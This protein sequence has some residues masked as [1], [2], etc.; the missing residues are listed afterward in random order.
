M[1]GHKALSFFF[2]KTTLPSLERKKKKKFI[3][4][5]TKDSKMYLSIAS[6]SGLEVVQPQQSACPQFDGAVIRA[7]LR[8]QKCQLLGEDLLNLVV[9]HRDG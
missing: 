1:H 8:K 4:L 9:D 3:S 6:C 7:L 5:D 2:T